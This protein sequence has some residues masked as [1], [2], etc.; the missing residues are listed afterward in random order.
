MNALARATAP[1]AGLLDGLNTIS[2]LLPPEIHP[3]DTCVTDV[4]SAPALAGMF[5]TDASALLEAAESLK[6]DFGSFL[7]TTGNALVVL[8]ST[9]DDLI[10]IASTA[11]NAA[12]PVLPLL[13]APNPVT[14]TAAVLRLGAI[15]AGAVAAATG[16]IA[17]ME[18]ALRPL[19]ARFRE[20]AVTDTRLPRI[21]PADAAP[22]APAPVPGPTLSPPEPSGLDAGRKAADAARSMV[23]T[24]Y[25]WGGSE[26]GGFDCSGLTKWAWAQAG[27]ELPRLAEQQTVGRRVSAEELIAG[28]LVVWNGHVAMYV[29]DG[30]IIEA[31]S[32][33]GISPLR[34]T[35]NGMDFYGFWRPTG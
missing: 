32:P 26:P 15:V 35:N 19:A 24:P 14:V 10:L 8:R 28:D 33:V 16:R 34:T 4:S 2:S 20:L 12:R 27:V 11:V 1:F 5:G 22:P 7:L 3:P 21:V 25:V 30:E 9:R 17:T 6:E 31:G 18:M 29:G 23:G 13:C